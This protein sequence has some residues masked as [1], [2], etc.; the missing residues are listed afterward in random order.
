MNTFL[1]LYNNLNIGPTS[2]RCIII[3]VSCEHTSLY[4]VPVVSTGPI[5]G[6][7]HSLKNGMSN[8]VIVSVV[9]RL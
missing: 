6:H 1:D 4:D 7:E 9:T 5:V 3:H 8:N 2:C